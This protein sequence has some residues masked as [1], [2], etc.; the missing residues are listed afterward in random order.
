M[1]DIISITEFFLIL[2]IAPNEYDHIPTTKLRLSQP[3]MYGG[4][5]LRIKN[6]KKKYKSFFVNN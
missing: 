1:F 3:L 4:N 6:T 2:N 5:N